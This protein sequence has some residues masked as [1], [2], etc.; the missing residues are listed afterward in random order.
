MNGNNQIKEDLV[1]IIMSSYNED[2][3]I[4]ETLDSILAQTYTLWELEVTDDASSD[5]TADTIAAYAE[6]D[7][8][9]HLHRL[10]ENVGAGEARNESLRNARG[11]F[12]AFIDSDDW[13]YPIKLEYQLSFMKSTGY[14]FTFSDFEYCDR[15]LNT[16]RRTRK[17]K[18]I[19]PESLKI[20]NDVNL[21]GVIY[22]TSGIGKVFF[23]NLRKRQDWVMLMNLAEKTGGAYSIGECL[24]KC[25]KH[26]GSLS[27]DKL[28]LIPYNWNVY[29]KYLG[30][31]RICSL[32]T[33]IFKFIPFQIRKRL[34]MILQP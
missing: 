7:S 16:L 24:W 3:Y 23:P 1:S 27:S 20:G 15:D 21:P 29:R 31:S 10:Y 30:Y 33:F 11:M 28:S 5:G 22:D 18:Y 14:R 8:R 9:I 12:I 4:S 26:Q 13:W 2:S 6:R 19:S 32:W 34:R 25:R 17:P